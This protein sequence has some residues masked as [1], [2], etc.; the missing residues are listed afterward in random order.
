[1]ANYSSTKALLDCCTLFVIAFF[2]LLIQVEHEKHGNKFEL[3][4]HQ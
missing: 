2:D 1:M 4:S 3:I